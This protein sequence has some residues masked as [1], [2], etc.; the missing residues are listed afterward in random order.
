VAGERKSSIATCEACWNR[1]RG[2]RNGTRGS[3]LVGLKGGKEEILSG[4]RLEKGKTQISL[5]GRGGVT[6]SLRI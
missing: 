6:H 1:K 2:R 4:C 3:S 5:G